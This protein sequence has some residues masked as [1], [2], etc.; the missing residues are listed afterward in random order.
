MAC[1][2]RPAARAAPLGAGCEGAGCPAAARA[3]HG[4][5]ADE[6]PRSRRAATVR[7]REWPRG[8]VDRSGTRTRAARRGPRSGGTSAFRLGC[9][10]APRSAGPAMA[11]PLRVPERE[12]GPGRLPRNLLH[13]VGILED[14]QLVLLLVVAVFQVVRQLGQGDVVLLDDL[15][16]ELL[17]VL[18][19][20]AVL[21]LVQVQGVLDLTDG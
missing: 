7:E 2:R 4:G 12:A 10:L 14:D 8:G 15:F 18:G 11:G 3:R 16:H 5:M 20:A 13:A 17:V 21:G 9:G 19:I 1:C 6:P